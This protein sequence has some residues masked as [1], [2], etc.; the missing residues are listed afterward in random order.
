MSRCDEYREKI[1]DNEEKIRKLRDWPSVD[2]PTAA[3]D[4]RNLELLEQQLEALKDKYE[5]S[6][7]QGGC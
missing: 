2:I 6:L 4:R 3:R 1:I 5:R 7:R